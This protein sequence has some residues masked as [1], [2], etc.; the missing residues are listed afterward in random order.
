VIAG[1]VIDQ[2]DAGDITEL[3]FSIEAIE[4]SK[5]APVILFIIN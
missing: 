5:K 2:I 3:V 1:K 4:A